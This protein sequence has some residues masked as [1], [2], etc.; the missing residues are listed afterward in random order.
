MELRICTACGK[1]H[2]KRSDL[3]NEC[4]TIKRKA[5]Q[6]EYGKQRYDNKREKRLDLEIKNATFDEKLKQIA[7]SGTSYAEMQ[8]AETIR[9]Y[10][11]VIV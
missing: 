5:Y 8:K 2:T 4:Y 11:R 6:I 3:C 9:L 7:E 10:G 1:S